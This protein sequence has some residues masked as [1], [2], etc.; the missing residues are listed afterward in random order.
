MAE[1]AL[2]TGGAA[3]LVV[4]VAKWFVSRSFA[5][6][7]ELEELKAKSVNDSIKDIDDIA[8]DLALEVRTLKDKIYKFEIFMTKCMSNTKSSMEELVKIKGAFEGFV[9]NTEDRLRV[10]E[11]QSDQVIRVGKEMAARIRGK[12]GDE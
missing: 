5:A 3:A 7:K 11:A 1:S 2:S 8:K 4:L 12:L 9:K 10:V 6:T